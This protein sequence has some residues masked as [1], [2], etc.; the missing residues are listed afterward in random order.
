M[1]KHGV[2]DEDLKRLAPDAAREAGVADDPTRPRG[3]NYTPDG[4]RIED[5]DEEGGRPP[6]ERHEAGEPVG[7]G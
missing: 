6:V 3:G 7:D 4:E 1:K 5:A 2:T